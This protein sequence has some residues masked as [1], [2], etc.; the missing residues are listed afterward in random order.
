MKKIYITALTI[1][2]SLLIATPALAGQWLMNSIGWWYLNTDGSYPTNTW[3]WI[4]GNNDGIA[5][6]YY[7]DEA[8]YC[9]LNTTAPN[10]CRVNANGAWLD[11][12]GPEPIGHLVISQNP[13]WNSETSV[14]D[15]VDGYCR[16]ISGKFGNDTLVYASNGTDKG[17]YYE[18]DADVQTWYGESGEPVPNFITKI[19]VHKN[20]ITEWHDINQTTY[21][22]E[23]VQIPVL[24]YLSRYGQTENY[25]ATMYNVKQD[26]NGYIVYFSSS[27]AG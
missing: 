2:I 4:D 6:C 23:T 14:P 27:N 18:F 21:Q 24:Q 22:W 13:A 10:G 3:Q 11:V 7:F 9:L 5:E 25:N 8:G 26:E 19:R 20:A 15:Q 16:D 17:D 12:A 1:S